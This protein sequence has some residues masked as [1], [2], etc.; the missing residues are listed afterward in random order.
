MEDLKDNRAVEAMFQAL[1]KVWP[2]SRESWQSFYP[3]LTPRHLK[4]EDVFIDAGEKVYRGGFVVSGLLRAFYETDKGDDFTHAFFT[5]GSFCSAYP[6]YLTGKPVRARFEAIED[7]E[8][9]EFS[10]VEFYAMY[11]RFPDWAHI[12]RR[13]AELEYLSGIQRIEELLV[14]DAAQR[15]RIF[16]ERRPDLMTRVKQIHLASYLG[17]KP[18]SLSRLRASMKKVTP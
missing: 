17:I 4:E 6:S 9:L 3:N 14:G 5:E 15:L 10:I 13:L 16:A 8:L 18:E 11:T 1:N 2:I 7:T 12:G